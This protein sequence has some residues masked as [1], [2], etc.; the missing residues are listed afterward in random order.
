VC[1][2]EEV[3]RVL[4]IECEWLELL[5][6]IF[7]DAEVVVVQWHLASDFEDAMTHGCY[8]GPMFDEKCYWAVLDN[9][10]ECNVHRDEPSPSHSL[11]ENFDMSARAYEA[12][13]KVSGLIQ[14]LVTDDF[15]FSMENLAV[16][17]VEGLGAVLIP[18]NNNHRENHLQNKGVGVPRD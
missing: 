4:S 3:N 12:L 10:G 2:V 5:S 11:Q 15:D 16:L 14:N 1:S 7:S 8:Q 6:C 17:Y 9:C 18:G 13:E